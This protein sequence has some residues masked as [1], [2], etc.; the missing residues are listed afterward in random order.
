VIATFDL[1]PALALD[2]ATGI[3]YGIARR[4]VWHEDRCTWFDGTPVM[5]GNP[6]KSTTLGMDV[7]A[8]TSG[9]GLVLAQ[10]AARTGETTLRETACGALRQ[11]LAAL[12]APGTELGFYGGKAGV[13]AALVLAG[14][15]LGEDEPIERGRALLGQL[16]LAPE[17]PDQNDLVSGTAGSI[18]ALVAASA[19]L[20]DAG[21]LERAREAARLLIGLAH[22]N[23][24][25]SLSW[26]TMQD[27]LA[28]L[29]GFAHGASGNAYALL[30]LQAVAPDPAL[31]DAIEGAL[32]Y[33]RA[34]FAPEYGNWPDYR[35]FGTGPREPS[36][37]VSWCHGAVGIV[38]T[39][40]LA[41]S[42]GFDVAG[43]IDVALDTAEQQAWRQLSDPSGD[44]TLC[45]GLFGS[46]D[47]L[48]DGARSGRGAYATVVARCASVAAER[49]H[50]G[51][52]PWPSGL[53]SHEPIDGLMM[54]NAGIG[55]VYLRLSDPSLPSILAP[56]NAPAQRKLD[57]ATQ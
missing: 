12:Y 15:E 23:E 48:L 24:D 49:H 7:Y 39:R 29:C 26:S 11:T 40:L 42:L 8:G 22:R 33:E 10:L 28:D 17:D 43:E 34:R 44:T 32:A 14:R 5:P 18:V 1:S 36:Y 55:H 31:R 27:K 16:A 56:A 38:R 57:V 41:E 9:I 37:P 52:V 35:W 13:G 3:G 50:F 19:A 47:A 54:G 53:M 20:G 51:D 30:A 2:V 4:A 21:L 25:G 6:P 45:H 46:L